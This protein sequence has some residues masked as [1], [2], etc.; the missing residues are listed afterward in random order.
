MSRERDGRIARDDT[1]VYFTNRGT[2]R[3]LAEQIVQDSL[4]ELC[5]GHAVKPYK[6]LTQRFRW[7]TNKRRQNEWRRQNNRAACELAVVQHYYEDPI[8]LPADQVDF[9]AVN[10][11]L[12]SLDDPRDRVILELSALDLDAAEIGRRFDPPLSGEAVRQRKKRALAAVRKQL[13]LH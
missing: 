13:Q 6:D 10:R 3:G 12:C 8:E 5:L 4:I 1:V 9:L 11:A 2:E 7:L